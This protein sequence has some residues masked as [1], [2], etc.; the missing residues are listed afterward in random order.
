VVPKGENGER[1]AAQLHNLGPGGD[2][3]HVRHI[4]KQTVLNDPGNIMERL[5]KLCR[6]RNLAE[7]A[8]QNVISYLY[9]R[10]RCDSLNPT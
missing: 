4:N 10:L 5:C 7:T 2:Q 8:I 1:L 9:S 6:I 3:D